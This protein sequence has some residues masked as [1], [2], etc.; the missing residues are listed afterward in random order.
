MVHIKL[1]VRNSGVAE[2]ITEKAIRILY[3]MYGI[4][5]KICNFAITCT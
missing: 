4:L 1:R 5:D 3:P 2:K